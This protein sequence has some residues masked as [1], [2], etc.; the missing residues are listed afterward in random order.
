MIQQGGGGR[1]ICMS[2]IHSCS[3]RITPPR[4]DAFCRSLA[5]E[6]ALHKITVNYARPG[7]IFS[8][9]TKPIYTPEVT[10]ALYQRVPLGDIARSGSR[11]VSCFSRAM[12]RVT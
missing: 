3:R 9:L 11:P 10:R 8:E 7:A 2:S 5:S 12:I 1:I 6:L 4:I